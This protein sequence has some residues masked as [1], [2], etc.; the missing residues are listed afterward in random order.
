MKTKNPHIQ[1]SL[2]ISLRRAVDTFCYVIAEN[3]M[4]GLITGQQADQLTYAI[5][6]FAATVAWPNCHCE[7][8]EAY[9]E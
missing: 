3:L 9:H 2:P 7:E 6:H 5:Y 1:T 4:A 8:C